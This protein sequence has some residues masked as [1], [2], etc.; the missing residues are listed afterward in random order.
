MR[1]SVARNN[2]LPK[3]MACMSSSGPWFPPVNPAGAR[4]GASV[5][6]GSGNW[7]NGLEPAAEEA[8]G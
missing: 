3:P 5:W 1:I 2:A 4:Q 7:R 8:V 6:Q